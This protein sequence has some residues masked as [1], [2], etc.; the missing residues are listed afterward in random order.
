MTSYVLKTCFL[1]SE[2]KLSNVDEVSGQPSQ[3]RRVL[4]MNQELP[5]GLITRLKLQYFF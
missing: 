4:K 5:K 2:L 3:M 1:I